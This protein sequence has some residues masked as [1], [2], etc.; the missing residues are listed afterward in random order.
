MKKENPASLKVTKD[1]H[2][3]F[4]KLAVNAEK[5]IDEFANVLMDTYERSYALSRGFAK[6]EREFEGEGVA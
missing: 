4:K 5:T 6:R 2:Q 1:T 3:R